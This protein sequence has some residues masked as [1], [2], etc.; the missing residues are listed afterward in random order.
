MQDLGTSR[1][2]STL[3][4]LLRLLHWRRVIVINTVV[5]AILAV[6]VSLLLPKWYEVWT[7]LLPPQEESLTLGPLSTG[8]V[9][10]ALSAAGEARLALT[11]RM[12][13][14]MWAS[15]SDLL[16]GILRSRRLQEAVIRDMGLMQIFGAKTIDDALE[17]FDNRARVRVG[18]EGIVYLRILDQDPQRAADISAACLREL[19]EIQRES[20]HSRATEVRKFVD[21]RISAT[22][23]DLA[24]AEDSLR[25]FEQRYGLLLPEEQV[26]VLVETIA[27]V[28]AERLLVAVERDAMGQQVGAEHPEAMAL[29]MRLRSLDE[30]KAALEGRLATRTGGSGADGTRGFEAG[31]GAHAASAFDNANGGQSGREIDLATFPDLNLAYLRLYRQVRI[32]ESLYQMLT[33]MRE[34]YRIIEVRDTPTIEVLTPPAVPEKKSKPHRALICAGATLLAFTGSLG[35]AA[36]LERMAM[37]AEADPVRFAKLQQLLTGIGLGFI[38]KRLRPRA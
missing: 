34:Q 29:D 15:A 4:F 27:K 20:R 8:D 11:G 7:S 16:S 35:I 1:K 10:E 6:I 21:E 33:Q 17:E 2:T 30:A 23:G 25:S 13:L 37:L 26:R 9:D 32:Q 22:T 12:N 3:D 5:V 31:N 18:A 24:S 38:A 14:P 36:A 19:D 28:E